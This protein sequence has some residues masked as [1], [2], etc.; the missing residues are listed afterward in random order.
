[1]TQEP[2]PKVWFR[3]RHKYRVD[4]TVCANEFQVLRDHLMMVLNKLAK[5]KTSSEVLRLAVNTA[6]GE[7]GPEFGV[8]L[9]FRDDKET[10][11]EEL[12]TEADRL[13]AELQRER[14]QTDEAGA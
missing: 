5:V 13:E 11:I 14:Q 7:D 4:L 6:S 8:S 10:R 1:M 12:R 2:W 9:R 3:D